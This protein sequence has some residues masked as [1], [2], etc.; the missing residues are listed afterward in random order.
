[1]HIR[2]SVLHHMKQNY[3]IYVS[4]ISPLKPSGHY[5]YR[6][7]N[8]HQFYVLPTQLYLCFVWI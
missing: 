2:A 5:M 3:F 1:M 4:N 6:Q 7:F 8:I